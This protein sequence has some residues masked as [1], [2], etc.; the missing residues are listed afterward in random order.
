MSMNIDPINFVNNRIKIDL[1]QVGILRELATHPQ[2]ET[3]NGA[4]KFTARRGLLGI[5]TTPL[6]EH[7]IYVVNTHLNT[8]T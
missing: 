5:T 2:N 8:A 3:G 6:A 7:F 1:R 4:E